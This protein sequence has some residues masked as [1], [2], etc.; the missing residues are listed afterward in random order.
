METGW[1]PCVGDQVVSAAAGSELIDW[2]GPRRR[3]AANE[4]IYNGF[5][6]AFDSQTRHT[7]KTAAVNVSCGAK[8]V[9]RQ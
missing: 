8:R 2:T 7:V 4:L 9:K 1:T 6:A 5:L 3:A